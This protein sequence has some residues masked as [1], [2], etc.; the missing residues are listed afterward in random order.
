MTALHNKVD[1]RVNLAAQFFDLLAQVF[2]ART[3]QVIQQFSYGCA[4]VE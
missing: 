3:L 1:F 4:D 2:L